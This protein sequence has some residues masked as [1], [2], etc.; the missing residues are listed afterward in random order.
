MTDQIPEQ[1]ASASGQQST[2]STPTDPTPVESTDFVNPFA[3]PGSQS[4]MEPPVGPVLPPRD[5][6]TQPAPQPSAGRRMGGYAAAGSDEPTP[7]PR[8]SAVSSTTPPE[9]VMI[10]PPPPNIEGGQDRV[11][12][13]GAAGNWFDHHRRTLTIW[14][15]GALVAALLLLLGSYLVRRATS[16]ELPPDPSATATG[17]GSP[18]ESASQVPVASTAN[19][20]TVDDAEL[21]VPGASW[22]VVDTVENKSDFQG[23]A[24]CLS[25]DLGEVNP[26]QAFQ[27]VLGTSDADQLAAMHQIDVFAS[28]EAAQQVQAQRVATLA[29]CDERPAR[30]VSSTSVYG[31]ADE[32]QQLTVETYEGDPTMFHTVLLIRN[33][34]A[35]TMVDVVRNATPVGVAE[36]TSGVLRSLEDLCTRSEGA[37]PDNPS[38]AATVPP[39][40]PPEGWLLTADLPR[41]TP[42]SGAWES[43]PG[44]VT[45]QGTA[46]ENLT[47]AEGGDSRERRTYILTQDAA[48]PTTFG[49][50][51]MIFD[52]QTPE[53]AAAF[54]TTLGNNLASCKDRLLTAT[55][56]ESPAVAGKGAGDARLSSRL[57]TIQQATGSTPVLYQA[58]V[59]VTGARVSYLVA[60]VSADYR[61]SDEQFSSVALRATERL[62][63]L[64]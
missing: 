48:A 13:E 44:E 5:F 28:D 45:F 34:R 60:T 1:E 54:V 4:A 37:C 42:G 62:S 20:L 21:I 61:F 8:R 33:G 52:F 12:S 14:V 59:G 39:P 24:A 29:A 27:R 55:V 47:L 41:I 18:S 17:P 49:L 63:Q 26:V 30:I 9:P 50:D 64:P 36:L 31:I 2:G 32:A 15:V 11:G 38:F 25:A 56:T 35:L 51:E 53:A 40:S 3:R 58:A 6:E 46:C 10:P 43:Q 57:F 19:L 7:A 23:R 16:P 22:V